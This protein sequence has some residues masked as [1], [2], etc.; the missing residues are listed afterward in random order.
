VKA[1]FSPDM[2]LMVFSVSHDWAILFTEFWEFTCYR[3][4]YHGMA[5]NIR[6]IV[7]QCPQRKGVFIN[8]SGF[9]QQRIHKISAADVMDHVAKHCVAEWIIAH[10]LNQAA[11]V[12]KR[13]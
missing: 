4:I 5:N 10:V 13:M 6:D 12:G 9:G 3:S 7:R 11:A 2:R 1:K 8:V